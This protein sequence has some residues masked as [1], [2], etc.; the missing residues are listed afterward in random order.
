MGT[1][2]LLLLH[3]ALGSMSQ[4]SALIPFLED[5]Y[6]IHTLD[7]EGHG[8]SPPKDRLFSGEHFGE[9]V[10]DYLDTNELEHVNVFGYSM[11]GHVALYLARKWPER[12]H[13]IFTLATKF[14]WTPEIAAHEITFLDPDT[15]QEKAPRFA[16]VLQ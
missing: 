7:F 6:R 12:I 10:L 3:G 8:S 13:S 2:D 15:I 5:K 4:F 11:G 14:L 1:V 16:M 9:N